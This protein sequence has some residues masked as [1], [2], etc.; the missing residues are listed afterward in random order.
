M[1]LLPQVHVGNWN[2]ESDV[3]PLTRQ[4]D[5][6]PHGGFWTSTYKPGI[7]SAWIDW[8]SSEQPEWFLYPYWLVTPHESA[9][10][11]TIQN[12]RDWRKFIVEFGDHESE[13]GHMLGRFDWCE[14]EQQ[15]DAIH[16]SD[17]YVY[18]GRY[19]HSFCTSAWDVEST[20]FFRKVFDIE[21]L[22]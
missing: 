17:T 13:Y 7:I 11:L 22:E 18:A 2:G 15:Y 10:I 16:M 3:K 6:K 4:F 14:V 5:H 9:N 8:C 19:R 21:P 12:G 20:C 1:K